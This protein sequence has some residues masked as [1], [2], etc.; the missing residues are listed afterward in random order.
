[1]KPD[2]SDR[3]TLSSQKLQNDQTPAFQNKPKPAPK[4]KSTKK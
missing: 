2:I 1:M 3:K 4:P